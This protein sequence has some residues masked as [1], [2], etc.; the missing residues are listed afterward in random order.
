MDREYYG[1]ATDA[2]LLLLADDA[3]TQP[4]GM[5]VGVDDMFVSNKNV[6]ENRNTIEKKV[7]NLTI[8]RAR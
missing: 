2:S 1:D 8:K 7:F 4:S 5:G 6:T 3:D